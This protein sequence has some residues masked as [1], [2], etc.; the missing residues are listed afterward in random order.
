MKWITGPTQ[1][2]L[3]RVS[4]VETYSPGLASPH[5]GAGGGVLSIPKRGR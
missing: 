4:C 5:T 2:H 3:T 1:P